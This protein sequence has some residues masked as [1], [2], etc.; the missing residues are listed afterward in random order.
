MSNSLRCVYV[1]NQWFNTGVRDYLYKTS[2][3]M[4]QVTTFIQE[5]SVKYFFF[6]LLKTLHF[7]DQPISTPIS[8][9]TAS[10]FQIA[11]L[12]RASFEKMSLASILFWVQLAWVK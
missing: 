6:Y 4:G 1:E 7:L 9:K 3:V 5:D 10:S 12:K 8:L 2:H 11:F